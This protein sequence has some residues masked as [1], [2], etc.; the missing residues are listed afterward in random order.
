MSRQKHFIL[1]YSGKLWT[2]KQNEFRSRMVMLKIGA[3]LTT[4]W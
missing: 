1:M 4:V 3:C 2:I